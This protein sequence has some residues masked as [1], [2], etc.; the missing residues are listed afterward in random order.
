MSDTNQRHACP[1]N[2]V[3]QVAMFMLLP[4]LLCCGLFSCKTSF[5]IHEEPPKPSGVV[6]DGL[7]LVNRIHCPHTIK[8]EK[9]FVKVMLN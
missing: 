9:A 6:F 1:I 8:N 5:E 7:C 3:S 2:Q 4:C